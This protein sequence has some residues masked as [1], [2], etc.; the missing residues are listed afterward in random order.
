MQLYMRMLA[1]TNVTKPAWSRIAWL[2]VPFLTSVVLAATPLLHDINVRV[3]VD[4]PVVLVDVD[5]FVPASQQEIWAV[6]TDFD[7]ASRFI[8][9]LHESRVI[10]RGP[11]S[12]VVAQKGT[13]G[14]GPFSMQLETVSEISLIP[15]EKIQSRLISGNMKRLDADT[16]L[17]VETGGT[18]FV[19]RVQSIPDIW[20]PPLIGPAMIELEARHRFR[21]LVDEILRRKAALGA[22]Q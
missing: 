8:D 13:M 9:K 19:Y 22:T 15:Y 18:R 12:M 16:T 2:I 3:K 1:H 10:S 14:F 21:Q 5:F 6:I 4:G 11:G 7:H 20:I 17:F